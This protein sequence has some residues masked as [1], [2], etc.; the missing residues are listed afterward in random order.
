MP[1]PQNVANLVVKSGPVF[2]EVIAGWSQMVVN[3]VQNHGQS[4][5]VAGIHESFQF[6]R[7][8]V[9]MMRSE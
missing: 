1:C 4:P 3:H 7:R 9:G 6:I 5:R 2:A 8:A